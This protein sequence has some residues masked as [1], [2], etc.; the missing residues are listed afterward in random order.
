MNGPKLNPPAVAALIGF[1]LMT[2]I[3]GMWWQDP[4]WFQFAWNFIRPGAVMA[5]R[6]AKKEDPP[7]GPNIGK[8]PKVDP[9]EPGKSGPAPADE[10]GTPEKPPEKPVEQPAEPPPPSPPSPP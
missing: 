9:S 4:A 10:P 2:L 8:G 3:V 5:A 6:L 1:M 7:P